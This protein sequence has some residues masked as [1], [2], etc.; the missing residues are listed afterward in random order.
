MNIATEWRKHRRIIIARLERIVDDLAMLEYF[1]CREFGHCKMLPRFP[2]AHVS[3]AQRSRRVVWPDAVVAW[4]RE[5]YGED[6]KLGG[7]VP[8]PKEEWG[9]RWHTFVK[10]KRPRTMIERETD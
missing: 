2:M 3:R 1:L 7:Y 4:V 6:L 8:L 5:F 10:D 9:G